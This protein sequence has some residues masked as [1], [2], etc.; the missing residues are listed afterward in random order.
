MKRKTQVE[1]QVLTEQPQ[2]EIRS[3]ESIIKE[4]DKD[5]ADAAKDI[6]KFCRDKAIELLHDC[7]ISGERIRVVNSWE[8]LHVLEFLATLSTVDRR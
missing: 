6:T 8:A 3:V 7:L 2:I 1:Q 4:I 5:K